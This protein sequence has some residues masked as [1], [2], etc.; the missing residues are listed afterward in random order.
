VGMT[1]RQVLRRVQLPLAAPVIIA[2]IRTATVWVVGI[3]T[4]ATPVGQRCLGNY[5][6]AGLQTRNWT[7]VMFGVVAAAVLAIV[8]DALI[9]GLQTAA[10]KRSKWLGWTCGGALIVIGVLGLA[11]PALLAAED[12]LEIG[13]KTFTE[14][15][16]LSRVI[17]GELLDADIRA[18]PVESLGSTIVFDALANGDI[19][20]YVDYTG[21]IWANYMQREGTGSAQEV[22]DEVTRWLKEE[23]DITCLGPLGFE[24]AYALAMRREQA[25]QLGITSI[26]DLAAHTHELKIGGD[27]EFFDRPEWRAIRDGYNLNFDDQVSYDSNLMYSAVAGGQ[28]DVISAF[29]S[30]GRIAAFDLVVLTDP[31]NVIPPYDA[32]LLLGPAAADSAAVRDALGPRPEG[33]SAAE[34]REQAEEYLR[35]TLQPLI[36]AINVET[37][38]RANELVDSKDQTPNQAAQWLR[39]Q[40]KG[41]KE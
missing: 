24:N 9:G 27:Y 41:T 28:V 7:A 16:I 39:E 12:D 37:M 26:A 17:A 36:D 6:F 13:S 29:S 10:E 11:G 1:E 35:D 3:A 5:I 40:L 30:D 22:L 21:T 20:V 15:Y 23:H 18:R 38:Q 34:Y 2:G 14:Q 32:V 19:D 4:L 33:M 31:R 8:L 25:E